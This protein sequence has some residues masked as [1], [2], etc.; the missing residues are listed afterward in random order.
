MSRSISKSEYEMLAEFRYLLRQ[1][2]RFSE[3]AAQAAR[4]G[5]QQHQAL[6]AIKGFPGREHLTI[7]ELAERLQLRHHSAV[8]LVNRLET[9]GLVRRMPGEAD[10]RQVYVTLTESGSAMLDQLSA[11]HR[12]ELRRIGPQIKLLLE[13]LTRGSKPTAVEE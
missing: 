7:G 4:L 1:F 12:D 9:Q 13:R 3:E 5:P 8:G 11:A 2:L 10:Q 6:L